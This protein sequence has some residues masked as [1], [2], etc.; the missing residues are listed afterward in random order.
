[1]EEN[2]ATITFEKIEDTGENRIRNENIRR[3]AAI[4]DDAYKLD[5][6]IK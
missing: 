4:G 6:T 1:M 5:G 3:N 2:H